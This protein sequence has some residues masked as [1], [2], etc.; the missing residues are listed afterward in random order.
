M[1]SLNIDMTADNDAF[2]IYSFTIR[3]SEETI[4]KLLGHCPQEAFFIKKSVKQADVLTAINWVMNASNL[5]SICYIN[6]LDCKQIRHQGLS[7]SLQQEI[8][9]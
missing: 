8:G 1:P 5:L 9:K 3:Y 7:V 2:V 6:N 4:C